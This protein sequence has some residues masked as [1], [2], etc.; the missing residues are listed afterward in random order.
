M[1]TVGGGEPVLTSL[2]EQLQTVECGG[3]VYLGEKS[4]KLYSD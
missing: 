2:E 1:R 3:L 4:E